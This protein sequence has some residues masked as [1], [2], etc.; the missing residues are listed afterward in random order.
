MKYTFK[1]IFLFGCFFLEAYSVLAQEEIRF[2][3][4]TFN[5]LVYNPA[6]AG[7][8][9]FMEAVLT[10]RN[11]WVDVDGSPETSS[12][13][14]QTPINNTKFGLGATIYQNKIGIQK[15]IALFFSYS[16]HLKVNHESF[17]S[18]GIQG[19]FINKQVNWTDLTTY[20]PNTKANDPAFPDSNISTLVPNF[21]IG[22]YYRTPKYFISFS[23]PRLLSNELPDTKGIGENVN[24]EAKNIQAYLGAGFRTPIRFDLDIEP[25][26]MFSSAYST[27]A[28]M[29]LNIIFHHDTGISAGGGFRTDKSWA[30]NVGYKISPRL[31][32]SYTY[33]KAFGNSTTKGYVNHEF[34]INYNISL[35]K[36]QITSPRYF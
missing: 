29:I 30:A 7:S 22:A 32:F 6:Y 20:D 12:L 28:N 14:V 13:A 8:T 4:F 18:L 31:K 23:L 15:D 2:S 16:Y 3:N 19:G 25:S 5:R 11:Q 27:S 36:S 21:G 1:I 9:D 17:L 10:H 26:V 34:I 33:E 35:K 24:F